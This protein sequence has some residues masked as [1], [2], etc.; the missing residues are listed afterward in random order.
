MFLVTTISYV[1]YLKKT[2]GRKA[3]RMDSAGGRIGAW[4]VSSGANWLLH[5]FVIKPG[6]NVGL[7]SSA[8]KCSRV[9]ID[10]L[11]QIALG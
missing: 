3:A 2:L 8:N 7:F 9:G 5:G 11:Q 4:N 6:V 10:F 1:A